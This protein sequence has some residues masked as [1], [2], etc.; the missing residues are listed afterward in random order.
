[1]NELLDYLLMLHRL[2]W[3]LEHPVRTSM[4]LLGFFSSWGFF[5]MCRLQARQPASPC[6]AADCTCILECD[7]VPFGSKQ[8]DHDPPQPVADARVCSDLLLVRIT[9]P[10]WL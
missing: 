5:I 3:S 2:G 7:S 1:M 10:C 8:P 6:G 4:L 9:W